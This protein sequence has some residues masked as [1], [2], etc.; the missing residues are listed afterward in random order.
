M[1]IFYQMLI[2]SG[3]QFH[4]SK[5]HFEMYIESH[6]QPAYDCC[7]GTYRITM[8]LIWSMRCL[9]PHLS[10]PCFLSLSLP[11]TLVYY[12]FTS[13]SC[14]EARSWCSCLLL[15][16]YFWRRGFSVNLEL[17]VSVQKH[18]CYLK[19]EKRDFILELDMSGLT[20]EHSFS[21]LQIP[22]SNVEVF[23]FF[24]EQSKDGHE[25]RHF[26]CW[27]RQ[28]RGNLAKWSNLSCKLQI[29]SAIS[30]AL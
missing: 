8:V 12:L 25:S 13:P 4:L 11:D 24:F 21:L 22:C 9:Q 7:W 3:L 20:W 5:Q 26:K 2:S 14:A 27:W 28:Q 29:L 6:Q 15:S 17:A 30:L 19:R 23:F 10:M 16:P 18:N 1:V